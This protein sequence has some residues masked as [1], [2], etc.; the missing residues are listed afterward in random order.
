MTYDE[1]SS[2]LP[3]FNHRGKLPKGIYTLMWAEFVAHFSYNNQRQELLGGLMRAIRLLQQAGCRTIYVGGSFIT[4]KQKPGD[5]DVVWEGATTDWL[6]LKQIAP[7]F[8]E[9]TPGSPRQKRMF[10]GEFFPAEGIEL[11]SGLT[12]LEFFQ[13]DRHHRRRGIVRLEISTI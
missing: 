13:R 8:F 1:L 7:V 2:A 9:M 6:Y 12:F 3:A 4:S 10:G 5:I 11:E